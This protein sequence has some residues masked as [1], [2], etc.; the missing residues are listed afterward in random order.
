MADTLSEYFQRR[1]SLGVL[2]VLKGGPHRFT[3]LAEAL[4]ISDSTLT[5]RLGEARDFGLITPEIDEQE[6]S[7]GDQYRITERGQYVVRK[8]EQLEMEHAYRTM[9]DMHAQVENGRGELIKW[10]GKDDVRET[11][12][13]CS[14]S[15]PYVDAFGEDVTNSSRSEVDRGADEFFNKE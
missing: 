6:T 8:M 7:V 4:H 10:V 9:L 5:A 2:I 3:D 15:D 14:D 13:R 11:I 12:A 1:G